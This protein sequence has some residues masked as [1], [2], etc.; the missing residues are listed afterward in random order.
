MRGAGRGASSPRAPSGGKGDSG[1]SAAGELGGLRR[2]LHG[3]LPSGAAGEV[4]LPQV[5]LGLRDTSRST[6][7]M[8]LHSLVLSVL[9]LRS[10][11]NVERRGAEIFEHTAPSSMRAVDLSSEGKC[12]SKAQL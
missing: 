8:T 2:G 1:G 11:G 10:E 12:D 4:T 3:A 5:W 9:L 7:A 6:V